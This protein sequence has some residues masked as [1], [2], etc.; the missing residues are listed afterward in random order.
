MREVVERGYVDDRRFA[1]TLL[2]RLRREGRSVAQIRARLASKGLAEE[3]LEEQLDAEEAGSERR[4]AWQLA[5]RRRLG[6]FCPDPEER[7]RSRERHLAVLGR[8]GFDRDVAVAIVDAP[9]S[10]S[11]EPASL[12]SPCLESP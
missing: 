1:T 3:I 5:K 12:E 9:E 2:A 6:P 7:R 10:P 4:A 8:Q 11:S